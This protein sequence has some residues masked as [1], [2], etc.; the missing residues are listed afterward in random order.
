M[1]QEVAKNSKRPV[2]LK[3]LKISNAVFCYILNSS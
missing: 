2:P 3:Q 1:A